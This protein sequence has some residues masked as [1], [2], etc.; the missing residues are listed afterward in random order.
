MQEK[1]GKTQKMAYKL[2]QLEKIQYSQ[3]E[4]LQAKHDGSSTNINRLRR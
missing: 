4:H 2:K 1:H 3:L